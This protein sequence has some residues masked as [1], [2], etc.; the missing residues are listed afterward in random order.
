MNIQD[1]LKYSIILLFIIIIAIHYSKFTIFYNDDG[2]LKTFYFMNKQYN[3]LTTFI[4]FLCICIYYLF[5]KC[6]YLEL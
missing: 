3:Y 1:P 5:V 4:V 2:S 6:Y